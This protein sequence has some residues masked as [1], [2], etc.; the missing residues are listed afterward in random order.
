MRMLNIH[1]TIETVLKNTAV[2]NKYIN[3]INQSSIDVHRKPIFSLYRE[4]CEPNGPPDIHF[5]ILHI[6]THFF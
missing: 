3:S 4:A 6:H 1:H 2:I 5:K